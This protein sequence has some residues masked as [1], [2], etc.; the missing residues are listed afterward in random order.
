MDE[1][2]LT[3]PVRK[4]RTKQDAEEDR[5]LQSA[6]KGSGLSCDRALEITGKSASSSRDAWEAKE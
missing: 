5:D 4:R 3:T 1:G 2:V 6:I